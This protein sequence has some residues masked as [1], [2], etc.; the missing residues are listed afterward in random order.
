[1]PFKPHFRGP[2]SPRLSV[3]LTLARRVRPHRGHHQRSTEPRMMS[4]IRERNCCEVRSGGQDLLPDYILV[5]HHC[6]TR[7]TAPVNMVVQ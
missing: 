2:M 7:L 3:A 4:I 5:R 1:M 6:E